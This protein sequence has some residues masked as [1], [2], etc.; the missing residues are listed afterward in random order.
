MF[1]SDRA[2]V[3]LDIKECVL[4]IDICEASV[5]DRGRNISFAANSSDRWHKQQQQRH[6]SY[7]LLSCTNQVHKYIGSCHSNT[8]Q[9]ST[10]LL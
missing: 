4:R 10:L 5:V 1:L 2:Q 3:V 7:A 8:M 6:D 9:G